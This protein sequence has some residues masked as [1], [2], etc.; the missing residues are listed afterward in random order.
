MSVKG[1][2]EPLWPLFSGLSILDGIG[3][4]TEANLAQSG[5][6]KP[7]D[8]LMELPSS[9]VDRTLRPSVLDYR[10]PAVATVRVR[11]GR[12]HPPSRKGLPH[13]VTVEDAKTTF[14]LVFFH[15]RGDY[16]SRLLP[17]GQDRVVSGRV[18]LFD[19]IPQIAHPDHVVPVAD[20]G[21]IPPFEPVYPLHGG[22]TQKVMFRATTS[23]LGLLPDLA[24]W[25]DPALLAREGWPAWA[26]ALHAA[27]RPENAKDM[28]ATA[29]AR[30]AQTVW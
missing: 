7:R 18:E 30:A 6:E 4:K 16:L 15:A 14:Q 24:E 26:E 27:H 9:G 3:P 25:I 23:G 19:N 13:R 28:A 2:P 20:A 22:I 11:V 1:R 29:P 8:L 21:D 12:H 10:P 17:T 5:I